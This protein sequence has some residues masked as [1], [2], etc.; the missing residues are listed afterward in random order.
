[1]TTTASHA[2]TPQRAG[3]AQSVGDK[4]KVRQASFSVGMAVALASGIVVFIGFLVLVS[5]AMKSAVPI[6]PGYDIR[7]GPD[8]EPMAI[9]RPRFG[10]YS[11][12][13]MIQTVAILA[14]ASLVMSSLTGWIM[15]Y[16]VVKPLAEALRLQR[17]FVADASHELRTPL[18]ALS[19]RI[20]LLQRHLDAGRPI[21][22][23]V[24]Q[25]QNDAATMKGVLND[26]LL[27]VEGTPVIESMKTSVTSCL[28]QGVTSLRPL[29]E[30]SNVNVT[31]DTPADLT[32]AVPEAS[33]TRA[34]VAIVDNAIAHSPPGS[35]V[36][37]SAK[38]DNR[39][40]V[41]RVSDHGS[42]I[43]G[44]DPNRVFERFAHGAETGRKRSFGLGLALA[45]EVAHRF[46]GSIRVESTSSRG[47]TFALSFPVA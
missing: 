45:S 9:A 23:M 33:L 29:A 14:V 47:T 46:N 13:S 4:R 37:V 20:Q 12:D 44:V 28:R 1:M 31:L 35:I 16:R 2:H 5:I 24:N 6:T 18:T 41:I 40:A 42:G 11:V 21:N 3:K 34:V 27:T 8:G 39:L 7:I 10:W 17:H 43:T 19:L 32:V 25:L 38:R 26:M 22:D 15:A 30:Q 36:E